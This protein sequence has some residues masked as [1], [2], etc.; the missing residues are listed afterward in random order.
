VSRMLI[1]KLIVTQSRNIPYFIVTEIHSR[2]QKT[3]PLVLIPS[4]VIAVPTNITISIVSV[5]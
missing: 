2:I 3:E 1:K 4:E 5:F